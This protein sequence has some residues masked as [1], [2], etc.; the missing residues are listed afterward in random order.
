MP[1]GQLQKGKRVG[2]RLHLHR[3]RG[4]AL[5]RLRLCLF[6]AVRGVARR[7]DGWASVR[8]LVTGA[9]GFIGR[10]VVPLLEERGHEVSE[11][12]SS[13]YWADACLHLAWRG[14]SGGG[15]AVENIES[16]RWS[17]DLLL[18]LQRCKRFVGVGSCFEYAP[19]DSPIAEEHALKAMGANMFYSHCKTTFAAIAI[20]YCQQLGVSFAWAR[21]FNCYGPNEH[22]G[23]LITRL[24]SGL[25]GEHVALSPGMQVRDFL[26]V[27]D[28]AS[29]LVAIVESDTQNAF[30]VCSGEGVTVRNLA[31][32]LVATHGGSIDTLHFGELPYRE[33]DPMYLVG[34]NTKLKSLGWVPKHAL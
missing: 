30:N 15:N 18:W 24:L 22:P 2:R 31:H 3:Y 23:R 19:S 13:P 20:P 11:W 29:A 9:R 32:R 4:R 10:H 7:A 6:R 28:V 34:D 16:L 5:F 14:K 1:Y 26:H 8:V 25:K 33:N 21:I 12:S 27:E 17:I